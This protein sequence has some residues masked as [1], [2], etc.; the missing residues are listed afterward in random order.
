[1]FRGDHI[2]FMQNRDSV[3]IHPGGRVEK[4]ETQIEA[5]RREIVEEA[6]IEITDI[7]RLGFMHLRHETPK[8]P[9][10]P[11]LY[12][13]FFWPVFKAYYLKDSIAQTEPDGYEISAEFIPLSKVEE[14]D[15]D[16]GAVAFLNA[17]DALH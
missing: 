10:Y 4:G 16:L 13:D 2:L 9:Q 17:A 11:F 3:H 6:G 7:R 15:L 5:L 1:M 8:P 12:P 14:L